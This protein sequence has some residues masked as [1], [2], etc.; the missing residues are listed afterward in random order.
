MPLP[1]YLVGA[2]QMTS[3]ADRAKNI[4]TAVR[5]INEAADLGAKLVGLPENFAFMG[6]DEDR[7][8]VHPVPAGVGRDHF[9]EH[10]PRRLHPVGGVKQRVLVPEVLRGVHVA[11][12][13]FARDPA[14][15][16][17]PLLGP[18]LPVGGARDE[19]QRR[20][21]LRIL[22]CEAQDRAAAGGQPDEMRAFDCEAPNERAQVF[23]LRVRSAARRSRSPEA[24]I[25]IRND[26]EAAAKHLHLRIPHP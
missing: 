13:R 16:G 10:V 24:A 21:R 14:P 17:H 5:L 11:G 23:L 20:H 2:V 15:F 1:A 7:I 22:Q 26:P 8:A 25:V 18:R 19:H 3:T 4:D 6:R 9:G 12:A